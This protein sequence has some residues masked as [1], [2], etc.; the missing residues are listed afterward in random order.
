MFILYLNIIIHSFYLVFNYNFKI[1]NI[2]NLNIK[3]DFLKYYRLCVT[4]FYILYF[5]TNKTIAFI[6]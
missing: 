1:F 6:S 2:S 5:L 4:Q 3:T